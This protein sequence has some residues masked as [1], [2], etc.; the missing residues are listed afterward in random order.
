MDEKKVKTFMTLA[1]QPVSS[2]LTS[3]NESV[4][5][6]GARL[7]LSETL[8]YVINGLGVQVSV[9][10]VVIED[11]NGLSYASKPSSG[12]AE[13]QVSTKE[14]LDGLCD[15]A[16]TMYWNALAFG[17]PLEEGFELVCD[18]NLEKFVA[19]QDWSKGE[20]LLTP[21]EWHCEQDIKWPE[22][23]AL[24]QVIAFEN[25][26]FAVGKDKGGKVCKPSH[27]RSVCLDE[28]LERAA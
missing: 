27:Y 9:G 21:S 18:N 4:R 6:L 20:C 24:V 3:A 19:L 2:K 22:S 28:L 13:E 14:M 17:L 23:V 26:F 8:E 7:L 11:P 15:V 10:D 5:S 16:Y 1:G 25:Q 12:H